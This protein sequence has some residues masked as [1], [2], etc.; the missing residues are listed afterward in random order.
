MKANLPFDTHVEEYEEWFAEHPFVFQSEVEAIR[1]LL[2]VG[3]EVRGIEVGL[4]T[5]QFSRALGIREGVEPARNMRSIASARGIDVING[6]AERLP[7]EDMLFDF[8]VM[9]FCVS[10]FE[11]VQAAFKEAHRVLKKNGVLVIGFLDCDRPIGRSYE[12]HKA[13]STFY[14]QA[15][16]FSVDK[17]VY[18]LTVAG[19]KHFNFCQTL[20]RPLNEINEIEQPKPGYGEGSF[21]VVQARKKAVDIN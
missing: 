17:I 18:E 9:A 4:G 15:R 2:P 13:D 8:V 11:N 16:F 14:R 6:V 12:A 5:G 7:Y 1:H 20:F 19:F 3:E 10:Y 21:V